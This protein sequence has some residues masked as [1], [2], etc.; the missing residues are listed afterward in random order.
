MHSPDS[1]FCCLFSRNC[2]FS[3]SPICKL[4]NWI[5]TA[6]N[7]FFKTDLTFANDSRWFW[8]VSICKC[9]K[10]KNTLKILE[11]IGFQTAPEQKQC[12]QN[13]LEYDLRSTKCKRIETRKDRAKG[14]KAHIFTESKCFCTHFQREREP[15]IISENCSY[16]SKYLHMTV[17]NEQ[18]CKIK[19]KIG[20]THTTSSLGH[21]NISGA[22][23]GF[24]TAPMW[25]ITI[26]YHTHIFNAHCTHAVP[27]QTHDRSHSFLIFAT[28]IRRCVR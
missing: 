16:H 27:S 9:R 18:V 8:L 22:G 24:W 2:Y 15:Q 23:A 14:A 10:F 3:P 4:L 28:A 17:L 13:G 1:K 12:T 19:W 5:Q 21:P 11:G 6:E 20:S 25:L 7:H 26:L